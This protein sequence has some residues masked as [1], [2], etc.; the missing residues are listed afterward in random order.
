MNEMFDNMER[1]VKDVLEDESF[2]AKN[3]TANV[4][5]MKVNE[6]P[7]DKNRKNMAANVLSEYQ[8]ALVEEEKLMHQM[9]KI[10]WLTEGDINTTFFHKAVVGDKVC[11]DVK[12][13][14]SNGKMLK[15]INSTLITVIPKELLKGY[16]KKGGSK[17]CS[18]KIDIAKAYDTVSWEFLKRILILFGFHK[19]IVDWICICVTSTSF[20]I[21]VNGE[22]LGHFKG[23]RG[24][25]QVDPISL[26]LFTLVMEV[27][28]LIMKHKIQVAPNFKYYVG[29]KEVNLT[30]LCFADDLLVLCY[31]NTDSVGVIKEALETFSK[32]SGLNPNMNKNTIFFSNMDIGKKLII[33][34]IMPFQ[35]GTFL[36]DILVFLSSQKDWERWN[37]NG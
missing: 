22:I 33:L 17:R 11:K 8:E 13:F 24:L 26:Y 10:E 15:E 5:N 20:S 30:Y 18:L 3:I 7:Y 14:F 19:K 6:Y 37:V 34:D 12:D 9:A 2:A 25:R 32:V 36:L 21:S 1:V 35:I 16:N 27:F 31:G 23:G 28:T 29:C 4:M